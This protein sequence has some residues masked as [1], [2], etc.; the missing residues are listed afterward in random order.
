MASKIPT[1][2]RALALHE[3]CNPSVYGVGTLPVPQITREDQ[4]LVKVHAASVNPIDVKLAG[5][6]VF[7][8]NVLELC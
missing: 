6:Y 8:S 5:Q 4:L 7:S 1:K 2:M 3:H